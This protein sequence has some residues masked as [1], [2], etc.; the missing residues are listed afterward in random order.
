MFFRLSS[1]L[2]CVIFLI[3]SFFVFSKKG[4]VKN[5]HCFFFSST[6]SLTLWAFPFPPR[7]KEG[8]EAPSLFF[9]P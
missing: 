4:V 1:Y 8:I 9:P 3:S 2:V 7:L 5:S 6:P